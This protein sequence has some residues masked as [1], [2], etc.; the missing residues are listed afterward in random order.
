MSTYFDALKRGDF[1]W[2]EDYGCKECGYPYLCNDHHPC[3]YCGAKDSAECIRIR[4]PIG[5]G[6]PSYDPREVRK[7][8]GQP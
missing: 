6:I 7:S 2:F 3:D 4:P 1:E 5:S 8:E